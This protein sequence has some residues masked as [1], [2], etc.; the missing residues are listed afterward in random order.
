M[1][2]KSGNHPSS[3]HTHF[4]KIINSVFA[5]HLQKRRGGGAC[6]RMYLRSRLRDRRCEARFAFRQ[7]QRHGQTP[8]RQNCRHNLQGIR[9]SPRF[10]NKNARF[11]APH[12]QSDR[13]I[14]AFRQTRIPVG[15]ARQSRRS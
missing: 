11:E 12:L 8:R 13:G 15:K 5:I 10:D 7:H 6:F 3:H 4:Y 1:Y 14:R 2:I 9:P